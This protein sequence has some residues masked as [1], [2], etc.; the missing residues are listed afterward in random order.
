MKWSVLC[1][2]LGIPTN[3]SVGTEPPANAFVV[4]ARLLEEL[5][6]ISYEELN[7][8]FCI[9]ESGSMC[10]SD[11]ELERILEEDYDW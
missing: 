10:D 4:D 7:T 1:S 8:A 11:E 2:K 6:R 3:A 9:L 5:M